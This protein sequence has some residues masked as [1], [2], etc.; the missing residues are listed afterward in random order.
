MATEDFVHTVNRLTVTHRDQ[1]YL[2]YV[3]LND[4]EIP[5]RTAYILDHNCANPLPSLEADVQLLNQL[6]VMFIVMTCNTAHYFI[7]TLTALS[8]VPILNM[9]ALAVTAACR[10]QQP[11][12]LRIGILATTGTLESQLYQ[13]LIRSNGHIPVIPNKQQQAQV[14]TLIYD[15]IKQ[16]DF[17]D[18]VKF[19]G[20][21]D[22]LLNAADCD[23]V[24]LGCTELSVAQD[25][26]PYDS[27]RIIDA[28][29]ELA[30]ATVQRAQATKP[31]LILR[32]RPSIRR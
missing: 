23:A 24:I 15:D 25:A 17:V 30:R 3:I 22:Q 7:P 26:A 12:P 19:H 2:N 21:I 5:D 4:A 9:P 27:E 16:R 10:S 11:R 8:N 29:Y 6:G 18:R 28:Q 14:M 32:R 1:D 13:Q 31:A 20:L